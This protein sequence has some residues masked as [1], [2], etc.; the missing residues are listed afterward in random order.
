MPFAGLQNPGDA[1]DLA[2]FLWGCKSTTPPTPNSSRSA[3]NRTSR[4]DVAWR[5]AAFAISPAAALL[6]L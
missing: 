4:A 3:P 2:A 1:D 6:W 5:D